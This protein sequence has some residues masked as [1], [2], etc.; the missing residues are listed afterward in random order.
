L[1][2]YVLGRSIPAHVRG[3]APWGPRA[4]AM[5]DQETGRHRA[6]KSGASKDQQCGQGGR[7]S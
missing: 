2:G 6:I 3:F 1:T 7:N 5:P 4:D